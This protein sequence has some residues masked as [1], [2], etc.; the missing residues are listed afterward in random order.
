MKIR[1]LRSLVHSWVASVVCVAAAAAA[2]TRPPNFI[3]IM[4]DDLGYGDLG[5]YGSTTLKSPNIDRLAAEG[6]R[7]TDFYA[8]S[9]KC[10]PT[11]AALLTG[12]Y[13]ERSGVNTVFT[14]VTH[15]AGMSPQ[16]VT[17]AQPLKQAGYAT[18]A[19][20]K[21]HVGYALE[22]NPK[23]HGFDDFRGQLSGGINYF[24]HIDAGG[25]HD[26]WHNEKR[27][28]ERGYATHLITEHAV[29]FIRENKRRPFC[30]YV[31]YPA[32]H[33]PHMGPGDSE[34]V[35]YDQFYG[36]IGKYQ[37]L[38][39][40][41]DE[42]V[43]RIVAQLRAEGIDRDT[44]IFFTSDNGADKPGSNAPL[45][46]WKGEMFEGGIRVPGI[47][48]WP[49]RIAPGRTTAQRAATMDLFPTMLALSGQPL[50]TGRGR[51][52]DGIDLSALL[53][54]DAPLPE[55][56]IF[57]RFREWR[58]AL[59]GPWKLVAYDKQWNTDGRGKNVQT[60]LFNL[61]DDP[62]EKNNLAPARP[63]E[64]ARLDAAW[65]SWWQDVDT[66]LQ[67]ALKWARLRVDPAGKLIDRER[68]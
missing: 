34:I 68:P 30:L 24:T 54:R 17:F 11:R 1:S 66:E 62:Q 41:A 38:L 49:G 39:T 27:V 53:L 32:V 58:A 51:A 37:E 15:T 25:H 46:G 8:N 50:P 45:R 2:E 12:R 7:F 43:G 26:W 57:F 56:P 28:P 23:R 61:A 13:P 33:I 4:L 9:C 22:A 60:Y 5:S 18:A 52:L 67:P 65:N 36:P 44:L 20:G 3:V 16:A 21:W 63:A 64:L 35:R 42:G 10:S 29:R 40:A 31:P 14:G 19:Y 59:D 48:W 55:R 47:A 6:L